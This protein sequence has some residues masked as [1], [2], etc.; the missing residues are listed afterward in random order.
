MVAHT[1]AAV[2]REIAH[3]AADM[4]AAVDTAEAVDTAAA[5]HIDPMAY[6][7]AAHLARLPADYRIHH[8]NAHQAHFVY[9]NLHILWTQELP[10]QEPLLS[11][12]AHNWCRKPSCRIH[13][14]DRSG[15]S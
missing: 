11:D 1:A 15:S 10:P 6:N 12:Y 9:H 3:T 14:Y 7:L 13:P 4:V 5:V 2:D 8:R